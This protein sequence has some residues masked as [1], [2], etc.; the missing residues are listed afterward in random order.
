MK[1]TPTCTYTQITC[2]R[3]V[4]TEFLC[5]SESQ[6]HCLLTPVNPHFLQLWRSGT[7]KQPSEL[8]RNVTHKASTKRHVLSQTGSPST[9][10]N[11][12]CTQSS[13]GFAQWNLHKHSFL[14]RKGLQKNP[15][16]TQAVYIRLRS[17]CLTILLSDQ[18]VCHSVYVLLHVWNC[19]FKNYVCLVCSGPVFERV[20]QDLAKDSIP[21]TAFLSIVL[22][23]SPGKT[24][25]MT[26]VDFQFCQQCHARS[27]S[28]RQE[29]PLVMMIA[30]FLGS[31]CPQCSPPS[32]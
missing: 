26:A 5:A 8:G 17:S 15:K 24:S 19:Y 28:I 6:S 13:H 31:C 25:A 3:D 20:G 14:I 2:M 23:T 30:L 21:E 11:G 18:L 22:G 32:R 4:V 27:T 10:V 7:N 9:G 12:N 1:A 16:K 29:F